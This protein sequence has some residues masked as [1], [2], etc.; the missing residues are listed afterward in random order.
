M[1]AEATVMVAVPFANALTRPVSST[2]ATA[3]LELDHTRLDSVLSSGEIVAESCVVW[4]GASDSSVWSSVMLVAGTA[5][6]TAVARAEGF[7]P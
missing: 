7:W 1:Y 5:V 4:P 2:V 3:S 6:I